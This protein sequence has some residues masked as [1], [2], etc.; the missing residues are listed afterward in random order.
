MASIG[1]QLILLSASGLAVFGDLLAKYFGIT[2]RRQFAV[3]ALVTIV[4]A[5]VIWLL[6]LRV[7]GQL[8]RGAV[9][10]SVLVCAGALIL[11]RYVFHEHTTR[12]QLVGLA[13]AILAVVLLA[14]N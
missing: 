4:L 5:N 6:W 13:V 7:G 8:G 1:M 14:I 2:G 9:I 12:L 10:F 11:G 3:Y